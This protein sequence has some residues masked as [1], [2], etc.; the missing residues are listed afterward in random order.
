MVEQH[1]IYGRHCR[2]NRK[3][4]LK[5][6]NLSHVKMSLASTSALTRFNFRQFIWEQFKNTEGADSQIA[7]IAFCHMLT[8]YKYLAYV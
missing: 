1:T 8:A 5:G 7:I 4:C 3:R 2:R 6:W